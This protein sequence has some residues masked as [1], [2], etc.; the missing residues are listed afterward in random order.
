MTHPIKETP[1]EARP[2]EH[3]AHFRFS[4]IGPLLAAPPGRGELQGRLQELAAKKWRHPISGEWVVFG[5]S[6]IERWFYKALRSKAS[7]VEALKRKIRSDH[8]QHPSLPPQLIELLTGCPSPAAFAAA[9]AW[10]PSRPNP[11]RNA[12]RICSKPPAIPN[13]WALRSSR[14]CANTPPAICACWST[15]PT[16]FWRR[17]VNRNARSSMK[18]STSRCSPWTPSPPKNREPSPGST[19]QPTGQ[20]RPPNPVAGRRFMV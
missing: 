1:S 16:I 15:W 4:V 12:W 19:R 2:H 13:C 8:G 11:S 18:N 5:V 9:C 14:R 3:W 17:P 7:P 10:K 6:T 20:H